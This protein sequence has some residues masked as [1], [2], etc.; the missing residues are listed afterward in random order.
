MWRCSMRCAYIC[1]LPLIQIP[2]FIV[3][4]YLLRAIHNARPRLTQHRRTVSL[5][6][7]QLRGPAPRTYKIPFRKLRHHQYNYDAKS[8]SLCICMVVHVCTYRKLNNCKSK[9]SAMIFNDESEICS[10]PASSH[11]LFIY[12]TFPLLDGK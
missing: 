3:R 8:S 11:L 4:T 12:I 5:T 9:H 2:W 7:Q 10:E 1:M 6:I